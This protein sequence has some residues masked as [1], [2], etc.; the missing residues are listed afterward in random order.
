MSMNLVFADT[1]VSLGDSQRL[2]FS[3]NVKLI[4]Q[5]ISVFEMWLIVGSVFL[6]DSNQN[7]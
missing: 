4:I 6:L 3:Q 2:T 5:D 7:K 1:E